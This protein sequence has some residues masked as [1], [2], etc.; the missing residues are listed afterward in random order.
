MGD[1]EQWDP[2]ADAPLDDDPQAIRAT[3]WLLTDSKYKHALSA[4][5]KKRGK[6]AT[7]ITEDENLPSFSREAAAHHLDPATQFNWD[8]ATLAERSRRAS[9]LF[10]QF[11]DLFDGGVKITDDLV[12]RWSV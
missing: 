5:A 7:T 11:P 12:L 3:L 8:A 4:Y 6:R 10:K 2:P 1:N 9:A